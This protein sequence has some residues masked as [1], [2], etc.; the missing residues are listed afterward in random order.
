MGRI[1][2]KLIAVSPNLRV[3]EAYL[4][5]ELP[6]Q[7]WYPSDIQKV[8]D[9]LGGGLP[10]G[11]IVEWYGPKGVGKSTLA[12]HFKPTLYVSV[13]RDLYQPWIQKLSP[14]TE[15]MTPKTAEEALELVEAAVKAKL[16]VCVLDSIGALV[17]EEELAGSR[18]VGLLP[19]VLNAWLRRILVQNEVTAV[20]FINQIRMAMNHPGLFDSP[21]G[22]FLKHVA[23][24]RLEFRPAGEWVTKGDTR[25]GHALRLTLVKNKLGPPQRSLTMYLTYDGQLWPSIIEARAGFGRNH[26][27]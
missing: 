25:I 6:P 19:R 10:A 8:N 7:K 1:L 14:T 9:F 27:E 17:P 2:P 13:E 5:E 3:K 26:R 21:G 4:P 15:F 24:Q 18:Q 23:S 20:V 11:R 12:L 16:E 22:E